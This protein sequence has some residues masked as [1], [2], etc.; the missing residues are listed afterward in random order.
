MLRKPLTTTALALFALSAMHG[1]AA[2][3]NTDGPSLAEALAY[4][5]K[6]VTDHPGTNYVDYP[7]EPGL[8]ELQ[9]VLTK[10]SGI[11]F[12]QCQMRLT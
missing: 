3:E 5:K 12:Q 2:G 11:D 7:L 10:P 1:S 8:P 9:A 6:Q 4:V